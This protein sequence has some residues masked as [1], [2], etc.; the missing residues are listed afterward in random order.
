MSVFIYLCPNLRLITFVKRA[1][2]CNHEQRNRY[3]FKNISFTWTFQIKVHI[4]FVPYGKVNYYSWYIRD[5]E[6]IIL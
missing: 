2:D 4:D 5:S 6:I 1:T 3:E